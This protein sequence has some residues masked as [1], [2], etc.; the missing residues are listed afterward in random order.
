[1]SCLVIIAA[2]VFR[3]IARIN[4]QT[5]KQMPVETTPTRQPSAHVLINHCL[6]VVNVW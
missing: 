1:M 6:S 3:D 4:R 5:D 2:S